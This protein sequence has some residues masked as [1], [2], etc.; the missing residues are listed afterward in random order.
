MQYRCQVCFEFVG[1]RRRRALSPDNE[2]RRDA[3][4][5][6]LCRFPVNIADGGQSGNAIKLRRRSAEMNAVKF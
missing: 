3:R 4:T 1:A 6:R 2:P 5:V